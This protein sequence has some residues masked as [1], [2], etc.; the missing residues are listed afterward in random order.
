VRRYLESDPDAINF[1]TAVNYAAN[2]YHGTANLFRVGSGVGNAIYNPCAQDPLGD[3]LEDVGRASTIVLM[4]AGPAAGT[5]GESSSAAGAATRGVGGSL[6]SDLP[7]LPSSAP[8]PLGLGSTGRVTPASL[9]EQL[10]MEE[11]MSNPSAGRIVPLQMSDP[12]WTAG[13]GWSKMSQNINGTE[14]HYVRNAITGAVDDF[15]FI[16]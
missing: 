1:N 16:R 3:V 12:R 4:L 2:V 7:G 11:A 8:K 13:T 9:G 5:L 14:I 10:A 15:K 6:E